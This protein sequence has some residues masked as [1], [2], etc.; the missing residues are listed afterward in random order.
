[1]AP[2]SSWHRYV[3]K[4]RH[5]L[6]S[7]VYPSF[8]LGLVEGAVVEEKADGVDLTD[9]LVDDVR[10]ARVIVAQSAARRRHEQR[11]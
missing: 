5:S 2:K 11:L 8:Q 3:T 7:Y 9:V 1:M 6:S 4:L 10:P